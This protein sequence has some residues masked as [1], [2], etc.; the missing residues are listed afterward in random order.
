MCNRPE[1]AAS[2]QTETSDI[3]GSARVQHVDEISVLGHCN[4][5]GATARNSVDQRELV[6]MHPEYGNAATAGVYRQ[7]E[8][9]IFGQC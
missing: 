4:R 2:L 8:R 5:L 7:Q 3:A 1:S 9:A 6:T